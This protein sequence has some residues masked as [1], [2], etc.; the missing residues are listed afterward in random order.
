MAHDRNVGGIRCAEVL[1]VL[2][3][4]LDGSL[5]PEIRARVDAHLHGCGWCE[6]FGGEYAAAVAL[7]RREFAAPPEPS[8]QAHRAFW[9]RLTRD[10]LVQG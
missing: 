1:Q 2:A 3:A 9:E 8:E 4:Y 10:G 5:A 6:R 7:L